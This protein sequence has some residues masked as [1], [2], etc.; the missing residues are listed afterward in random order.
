MDQTKHSQQNIDS[1]LENSIHNLHV[2]RSKLIGIL[3]STNV[4]CFPV[5][6][7]SSDITFVN[8]RNWRNLNFGGLN[9]PFI[10]LVKLTFYFS[11]MFI[12]CGM[13]EFASKTVEAKFSVEVWRCITILC[14][15]KLSVDELIVNQGELNC[16]EFL[17]TA[18]KTCCFCIDNSVREICEV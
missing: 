9:I 3:I 6:F 7:S 5:H 1:E 16:M 15:A 13:A 11:V 12:L 2:L 17:L 4:K 8:K 10:E 14:T 18:V